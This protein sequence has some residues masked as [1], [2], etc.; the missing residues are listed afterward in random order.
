MSSFLRTY[1][2]FLM[3]HAQSIAGG[4][5]WTR[6]EVQGKQTQVVLLELFGRL[7][8][9]KKWIE[10]ADMTRKSSERATCV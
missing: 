2:H 7:G 5:R 3:S 1:N 8:V 10:A 4:W 6:G 9:T